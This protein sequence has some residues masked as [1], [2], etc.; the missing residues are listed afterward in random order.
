MVDFYAVWCPPCRMIE[1]RYKAM[2]EEFPA[3]AFLKVDVDALSA[4]SAKV[5]ISAMPTFILYKAG[6][7]AGEIVGVDEEGLRALITKALG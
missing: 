1:P 6:E 4:V 7:K 5:G 3:V 2:S